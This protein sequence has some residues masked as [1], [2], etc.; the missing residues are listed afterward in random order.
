MDY[1]KQIGELALGSRLKRLGESFMS[2]V[3]DLY[4]EQGIDFEPRWFPL[5]SLLYSGKDV[6][7]TAAATALNLTHPHVSLL[8]KEMAGAKLLAVRPHAKDARAKLLSLTPKGRQLGRKLEPAWQEIR[9]GV[10]H[11]LDET[12]P[13]FLETLALIE[14]KLERTPFLQR[15]K[16]LRASRETAARERKSA[17]RIVDYKP[18]LRSS[19]EK[20][21]REWI[22][23]YF[24]MEE[25]DHRYFKDP[26]SEIIGLGGDIVFAELGGEIVGTCALLRDGL[27]AEDG[28][29]FELAKLAVSDKA[30]GQGIGELLS[31]EILRR[32]R[33][34][35]ATHVRLTTNTALT[36]ALRLY[37]KLGFREVFKGQHPKFKRVDLV[38]E[39]RLQ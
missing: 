39:K 25:H 29:V 13:R 16:D 11:V 22:E 32:A 34:K 37:E 38:M 8:A 36:P 26:E 30:K 12:D 17:V 4:A 18:S 31:Q 14:Q 3:K 5:F 10:R 24:E 1:F 19:F 21:N 2:E 20:L 23:R 33:E 6:S 35:G 9:A 28:G 7:V 15:V 27:A